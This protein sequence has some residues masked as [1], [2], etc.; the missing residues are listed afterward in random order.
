MGHSADLRL[1]SAG[2][3]LSSLSHQ[4]TAS[5]TPIAWARLLRA[6]YALARC[7]VHCSQA[8][9]LPNLAHRSAPYRRRYV[10]PR[11]ETTLRQKGMLIVV[12]RG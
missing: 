8:R 11:E 1:E 12:S 6:R 5:H 3:S 4:A 2:G 10:T 9:L 7:P